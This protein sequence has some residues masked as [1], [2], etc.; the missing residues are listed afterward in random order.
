MELRFLRERCVT[1]S[2]SDKL[3]ASELASELGELLSWRLSKKSLGPDGSGSGGPDRGLTLVLPLCDSLFA[4]CVFFGCDFDTFLRIFP[5]LY[6]K[7]LIQETRISNLFPFFTQHF[8]PAFSYNNM[9]YQ[10]IFVYQWKKNSYD[11]QAKCL[12]I[13]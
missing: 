1:L 3:D 4:A 5:Y 9:Y 11:C 10:F 8:S 6:A 2:A 7:Q 13:L 12:V